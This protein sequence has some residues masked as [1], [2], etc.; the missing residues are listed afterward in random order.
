MFEEWFKTIEVEIGAVQDMLQMP[1]DDNPRT[2]YEQMT[3]AES[4]IGRFTSLHAEACYWLEIAESEFLPSKGAGSEL[5]RKTSQK[6]ST[7]SHRRVRNI[8][9]GLIESLRMRCFVGMNIT[10][11]NN[12]ERATMGK[13]NP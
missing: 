3:L 13:F 6:A 4:N 7:A 2:I 12:A 10:K 1:L 9:A 5:D 11:G 8:L